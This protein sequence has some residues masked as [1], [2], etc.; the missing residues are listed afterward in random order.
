M[1]A[2][3]LNRIKRWVYCNEKRYN[4][5]EYAIS[6]SGLTRY[7]KAQAKSLTWSHLESAT[8]LTVGALAMMK[9]LI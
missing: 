6:D 1:E 3:T 2:T 9:H 8:I 7:K 5:K 4:F